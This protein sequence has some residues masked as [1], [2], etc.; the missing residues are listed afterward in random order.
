MML[1]FKYQIPMEHEFVLE[2]PEV[3][4]FLTIQL[5]NGEPTLWVL[6]RPDTELKFKQFVIHGT[7]RLINPPVE[8]FDYI[9]TWQRDGF[10]WHLFKKGE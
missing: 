5:Q 7:G 10:V 2:M 9:G 4:K 1:I 6:V 3:I 8:K